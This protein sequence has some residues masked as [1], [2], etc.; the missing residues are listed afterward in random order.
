MS[1]GTIISVEDSD[2]DFL[3][4]RHALHAAGV[5]NPI[6]R[7]DNGRTAVGGLLSNH[8]RDAVSISKSVC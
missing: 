4:L 2:T 7:Y 3:A 8:D 6:E 5:N 1:V